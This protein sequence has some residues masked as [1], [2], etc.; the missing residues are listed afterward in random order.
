MF[1]KP[2]MFL[3][4]YAPLFA[5]LAIRVES[6]PVR[7]VCVALAAAGIAA[8]I[9]IL[10]LNRRTAPAQSTLTAVRNAGAEA[11]SY[12]AGYLLP[13]LVVAQPTVWDLTAYALFLAVVGLVTIKT[14]VI[15]VNRVCCT[16][17]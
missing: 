8:L 1:A 2:L 5:I 16:D 14:G 11:A 9:A 12:L 7:W 3:S 4:S 13:F 10:T 17:R 15:Q 6:A